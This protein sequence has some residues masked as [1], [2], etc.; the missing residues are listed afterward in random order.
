MSILCL[1]KYIKPFYEIIYPDQRTYE[2]PKFSKVRFEIRIFEIV[3]GQNFVIIGKL[4]VFGPK[5]PNLGIYGQNFR[6]P[7]SNLKSAH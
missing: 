2:I 4:I 3:Y 1:M 6:K 5:C 7:V